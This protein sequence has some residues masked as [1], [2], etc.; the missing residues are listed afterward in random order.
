MRE[1]LGEQ[2]REDVIRWL[3]VGS[4]AGQLVWVAIVA[5]A[6]AIEPGYSPVRDPIS[7]LGAQDAAR[8]W[9]FDT[10][11]AIWGLS[12]LAAAAALWLDA[13]PSLRGRLGPALIAFTGLAEILDGFPLPADCRRTIDPGCHAREIAGE[14]SW[15]QVAHGWTFVFGVLALGLSVFAM[16]WRFHG[17]ERWGPADR[18]ALAAGAIGVGIVVT[19]LFAVS[20]EAGGHYGLFQRLALGAGA[21]WVLALCCGLLFVHRPSER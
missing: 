16:A 12:F 19:L 4:I 17:D 9:L 7:A 20:H 11:V 6:G 5:F 3:A 13:P 18:L 15:R 14:V 10:G 2:R 1:R 8:P 21:I